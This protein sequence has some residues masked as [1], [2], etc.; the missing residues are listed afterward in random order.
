MTN[1][2]SRAAAVGAVLAAT[3]GGVAT[4]AFAVDVHPLTT[5]MTLTL[6]NRGKMVF[7]D[8]G[9]MFEVCDTKA[10][11]HGMTGYLMNSDTKRNLL[12][13]TDGGD[14]GCDKDGWNVDNWPSSY[15]MELAWDGGGPSV[16]SA[17]FNE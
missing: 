13:I 1:S 8:D 6:P 7:H 3:L 9:D 15:Q 10:D 5:D 14:A 11:G 4:P 17:L 2:F 16:Y 12:I